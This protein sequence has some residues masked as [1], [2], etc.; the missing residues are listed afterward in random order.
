MLI[1]SHAHL[2]MSRFDNDREAVINRALQ[3]GLVHIVTVGTDIDDSHKAVT[4]A[5]AYDTI[6]AT[7]GVHPH[8]VK[9]I[10]NGTYSQLKNLAAHE[11]VVAIG[12]IGLDFYRNHSPQE[13]QRE[14][15]RQQLQLAREVSLPVVIH[16][17]DAH[18]AVV[19]I[20]GEE[21]A[22]TI[23]GVIHCF[24]GDWDMAKTCLDMGFYISIPGTVT[25]KRD[26]VYYDIIRKIPL[27]R[28]LVE[29]DCPFLAPKPFRGKRNEPAYVRSVA[30][31]VAQIKSVDPAELGAAVTRNAIELFRS[32]ACVT[33][34]PLVRVSAKTDYACTCLKAIVFQI[35]EEETIHFIFHSC[36]PR[37][38]YDGNALFVL[39]RGASEAGPRR[40]PVLGN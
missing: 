40:D 20:L 27:D 5:E 37:D 35:N 29:T 9:A 17:R 31:A 39:G 7:V 28:L 33:A 32:T 6:S 21:H 11:N 8:D 4:L 22:E 3:A 26:D 36:A 24:S 18:N 1:D 23:G 15:F 2:T 14:H 38:R 19:T 16:D 30:E 25:F 34:D 12:E 10:D 13:E